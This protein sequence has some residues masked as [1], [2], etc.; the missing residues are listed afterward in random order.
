MLIL[1]RH[2]RTSAN[3][4]GLL[5][6][7][8]DNELDEVGV[9]QATQIAAA[10]SRGDHR[11]V[12]IVSSPLLR[13]RQTAEATSELLGIEMSIDERWSELDYG[14]WDGIPIS[15]VR[16]EMWGQWRADPEFT[17]PGGES[18]V[19]LNDRV[20]AACDDLAREAASRHIAVFTHVSPIKSAVRWALGTAEEI[21]WRMHVAQAQITR[22]GFRSG[23]P[24]LSTFNDTSHLE[25]GR[26]RTSS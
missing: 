3:A 18:L 6:G 25:P 21:G 17:L 4:A 12:R 10:L 19:A 1:V 22:I 20:G 15:E 5:Q 11:P 14:E 16:A 8:V 7:R 9:Q 26:P 23:A 24:V 13:A 2:G